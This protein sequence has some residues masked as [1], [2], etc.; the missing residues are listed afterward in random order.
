MPTPSVRKPLTIAKERVKTGVA[1]GDAVAER[2]DVPP[3]IVFWLHVEVRGP[4]DESA[5]AVV[6]RHELHR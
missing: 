5:R 6:Q 4:A 2:S 3:S 1:C